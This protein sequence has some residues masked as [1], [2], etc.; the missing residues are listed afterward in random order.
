MADADFGQRLARTRAAIAQAGLD[1]LVITSQYNRRYLTGFTAHDGDITESSGWVLVT[2]NTFGLVAGT[3]QLSGVEDE[4]VPSGVQVLST[5]K[6]AS[7]SVVAEAIKAEGTKRLGFEKDWISYDRYSRLNRELGADAE[8]IPAD[9][10]VQLV[11]AVKDAAE[12]ATMRRAADVADQAFEQL[13]TEIKVGMTEREIATLLEQHMIELG[14]SGTSFS[15]IVACGP[16]GAQPHA[17]PTDRP[18]RP[19]E[20]L[21]IDFGCRV[22]GYCS[23]TTRTFCIGEPDPKL[24]ELYAIVREAQDA[25]FKALADGVRKGRDVDMAARK[26]IEDAG[27]GE[28]YFHSLGHG[29]GL[30]I[31]ELPVTAT[32]RVQTPEADAELA[33]REQL[34]PNSVITNEPGIYIPGWGGVRLEDMALVTA[35]GYE[36]MTVRNPEHV[37]SIAG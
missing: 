18:V 25:G 28:Q 5:D 37:R 9:D 19:G 36:I 30:A 22:D 3:F 21:L 33:K 16:G 23:D 17:V 35:D 8:L 7:W 12:I 1:G 15:T 27:Y 2:P 29:V 26:V 32:L 34:E 13:L 6:A 11:R 31:H 10:M 24:T 14:A 4:I 20:P